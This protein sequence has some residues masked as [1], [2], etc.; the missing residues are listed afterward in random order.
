MICTKHAWTPDKT[1]S[2]NAYFLNKRLQ[3]FLMIYKKKTFA[4]TW[5]TSTWASSSTSA[6]WR[7]GRSA[8]RSSWT[9]GSPTRSRT[10]STTSST[11]SSPCTPSTSRR[12]TPSGWFT[13][14]CSKVIDFLFFFDVDCLKSSMVCVYV[15]CDV[16]KIG[17][18][19]NFL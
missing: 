4:G 14:T 17:L 5:T 9:W 15:E 10:S 11:S 8:S 13:S 16:S 7:G 1:L 3:F 18:F 12:P 6:W 19:I 2:T